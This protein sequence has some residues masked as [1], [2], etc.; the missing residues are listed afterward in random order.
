MQLILLLLAALDAYGHFHFLTMSEAQLKGNWFYV[1]HVVTN[2]HAICITIHGF[3]N[4]L[5]VVL[6]SHS[7]STQIH[8]N[9]LLP[10]S[11]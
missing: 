3:P 7:L 9:M 6:P 2:P 5:P 4:R 1:N 8:P 10:A 11:G